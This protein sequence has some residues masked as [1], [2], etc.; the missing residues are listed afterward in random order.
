M[1]RKISDRPNSLR[2]PGESGRAQ[3]YSVARN[4]SE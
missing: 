3:A 4:P 1:H 2:V